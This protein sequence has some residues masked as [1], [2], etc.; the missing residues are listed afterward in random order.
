MGQKS[1]RSEA[2]GKRKE[3]WKK[4]LNVIEIEINVINTKNASVSNYEK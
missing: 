3:K 2:I 4:N 1:C